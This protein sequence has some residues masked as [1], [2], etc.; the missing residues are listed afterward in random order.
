MWKPGK[1][2]AR[3]PFYEKKATS[4][5]KEAHLDLEGVDIVAAV[6]HIALA[7]PFATLHNSQTLNFCEVDK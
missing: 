2:V 6:G 1:T 4:I 5:M 3:L 7:R